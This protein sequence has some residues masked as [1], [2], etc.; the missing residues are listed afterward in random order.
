MREADRGAREGRQALSDPPALLWPR[1]QRV[2]RIEGSWSP[3]AALAER[4]V[5]G[6]PGEGYRLRLGPEGSAAEASDAAGLR[7]ARATF[8]QIRRLGSGSGLEIED[9]PD[10]P[11]RGYLLDVSRTRVPTMESLFALVDRLA[12]LK[13]NELQL[14][15]EHTFA[16]RDHETVW[17]DSSPMTHD[18]VRALDAR[19]RACGIDLVPNQQSLGH[20]HRWLRHDRYRPLAEVPEGV[21]HAFGLEKEPF[22]L[23]PTDPASLDFLAGLYD[24]LLPCFSSARFNVGL[25]ETFDVGTGRSRAPCESRGK[26]RVHLE[27]L[28]SVQALARDRGRRIQFW[29]D[30][31]EQH[32]E[33]AGEIPRDAVPMLWGYEAGHSFAPSAAIAREH[34]LEHYVCPGTSSWQSIAGRPANA[35]R[36]LET[37]AEEGRDSGASGFLV[38]DWGDRGHL[39][40]AFASFPGLV[41]GAGL[42]WNAGARAGADLAPLLDVHAFDARPGSGLGRAALEL[43]DAHL[44]TGSPATNG[45]ALFFLIAFAAEPLPHPR[46]PNLSIEGLERARERI[47]T[48]VGSPDLRWAAELLEA[49][50]DLGIARL[51]AP[52]GSSLRDLPA[53]VRKELSARFAALARTHRARWLET[54]RPGGLEESAGWLDRVAALL[55]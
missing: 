54:S 55:D 31:V 46:M 32:P 35:A 20:M 50:C 15:T 21:V 40:P 30:F 12:S 51:R 29:G 48:V 34:G 9:W 52:A 39:Q 6:R 7:H 27:F 14:Y 22:S 5:P 11:R 47:R 44:D 26:G 25:D 41:L 4:L 8:E 10:F 1:P 18:E 17:R 53:K 24:E 3:D 45:S 33:L 49:S 19:C 13:V 28:R 23:C 37:A 42:A 38:T 43:G 36:N 2:A 16:Y